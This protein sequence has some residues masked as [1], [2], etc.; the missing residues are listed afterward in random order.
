MLM[1]YSEIMHISENGLSVHF[2]SNSC[3]IRNAE[4]TL[5]ECTLVDELY[6]LKTLRSSTGR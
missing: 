5:A 4:G 6:L 1:S 2:E 3:V